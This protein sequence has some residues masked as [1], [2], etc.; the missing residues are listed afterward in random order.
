[1]KKDKILK[2]KFPL[3]SD[4]HGTYIFDADGVMLCE[5]RGWGHLQKA[6]E[7]EGIEEQIRRQRFILD[8][9]NKCKDLYELPTPPAASE[10]G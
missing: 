1:M 3:W 2:L 7:K 5:I 8:A 4:E 10:E 9:C 6:G